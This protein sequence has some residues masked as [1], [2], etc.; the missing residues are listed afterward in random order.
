MDLEVLFLIR[1]KEGGKKEV[2]MRVEVDVFRL[3]AIII[4][5]IKSSLSSSSSLS[6]FSFIFTHRLPSKPPRKARRHEE[7][8]GRRHRD[9]ECPV[10][11]RPGATKV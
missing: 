11:S 5:D 4:D 7:G 6:H 3:V 9:S 1:K 2:V 10:V 8:R